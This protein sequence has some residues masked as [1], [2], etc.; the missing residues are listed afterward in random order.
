MDEV[1]PD[2]AAATFTLGYSLPDDGAA[3]LEMLDVAGRTVQRT[4]LAPAG[5]GRHEAQLVAPRGI[6]PGIYCLRLT[7]SGRAVKRG[8]V[9]LP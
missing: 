5:A 2:P 7:Q 4:E 1:R 8:V 3:R 9:L 6:R